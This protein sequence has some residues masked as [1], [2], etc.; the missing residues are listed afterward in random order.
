[1]PSNAAQSGQ[2]NQEATKERS[3]V[4]VRDYLR[5]LFR[6]KWALLLPVVAGVLVFFP[7]S[8]LTPKTYRAVAMVLQQDSSPAAAISTE[9]R[10]L[11]VKAIEADIFNPDNLKE[12]V[13]QTKQDV[14]LVTEADRQKKY[15]ELRN[16]IHVTSVAQ[17]RG[18]DIIQFEVIHRDPDVA[19]NVANTVATKF[20]ERKKE[21]L[22]SGNLKDIN[23]LQEETDSYR[24]ALS[25][26]EKAIDAYRSTPFADLP[27]VKNTIRNRLLQLRIDQDAKNMELEATQS[28]MDEAEAQLKQVKPSIQGETT[29]E[30]NPTVTDLK[31]SLTQMERSLQLLL[32]TYTEDHPDVVRLHSQIAAIKEQLAKEPQRINT[33]EKEIVNPQYQAL[34]TDISRLKQEIKGGETALRQLGADVAANDKKLHDVVEQ[35]KTYNDLVRDQS[36]YTELWNTYRRQ[37]EEAQLRQK[38][39]QGDLG[40]TVEIY[41]SA[42]R[43]AIPYYKPVAKM[44]LVCLMGGIG[45]G[46]MLMFGLEFCDRSFRSMDDAAAFLDKVPVLGSLTAIVTPEEVAAARRRRR[47]VLRGIVLVIALA[48]LAI[49]ATYGPTIV[50]DGVRKLMAIKGRI[51]S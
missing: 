36:R 42:I 14:D 2:Q 19:Q 34:N 3:V 35:E 1:M 24:A 31:A 49:G 27:D 38:V 43:P 9:R 17:G 20:V 15:E 45:A 32:T 8:V 7:V 5:M 21:E 23:F 40:T 22:K 37:L 13:V 41:R 26:A 44:A 48:L 11:Q 39:Q 25:Q 47:L 18:T 51:S 46:I 10:P 33:S 28:R 12:V 4:S 29:S 6:R 50:V 16:A 30:P